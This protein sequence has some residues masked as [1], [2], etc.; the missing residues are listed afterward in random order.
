MYSVVRKQK[1]IIARRKSDETR[2]KYGRR[3]S[4]KT[5]SIIHKTPEENRKN[6]RKVFRAALRALRRLERWSGTCKEITYRIVKT[7]AGVTSLFQEI[8]TFYIPKKRQKNYMVLLGFSGEDISRH[9]EVSQI[10]FTLPDGRTWIVDLTVI[11]LSEMFW[12]TA[13]PFLSDP[14]KEKVVFDG[15]HIS[16]YL[17]HVHDIEL[18]GAYDLLVIEA[19]ERGRIKTVHHLPRVAGTDKEV[20]RHLFLDMQLI[21]QCYL[22]EQFSCLKT[23]TADERKIGI[24]AQKMPRERA[25]IWIVDHQLFLLKLYNKINFI[26]AI[27]NRKYL[28]WF[29]SSTRYSTLF[30]DKGER[31]YDK[32]ETSPL[33]PKYVLSFKGTDHPLGICKCEGCGRYLPT[34][35]F[36]HEMMCSLKIKMCTNC[37]KILNDVII[38]TDRTVEKKN[39]NLRNLEVTDDF[40]KTL[41]R[42]SS[43]TGRDIRRKSTLSWM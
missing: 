6:W 41:K 39:V 9:G 18:E 40:S 22:D 42:R 43:E 35:E 17:L 37:L 27:E 13:A 32:I 11:P 19:M 7:E 15:K 34:K 5:D 12:T 8:D 24:I 14:Q 3:R 28:K 25:V 23:I 4:S 16:D 1:A 21:S 38:R 29:V 20:D 2:S 33:I 36:S 31:C 26:A 30:S 10:A